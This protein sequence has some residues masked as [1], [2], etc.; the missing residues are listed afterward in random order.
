[1]KGNKNEV[2]SFT[3]IDRKSFI[4]GMVTAFAEC[5]ANECKK[6]ALSPPFYPE[7]YET[8]LQEVVSIAKDQGIF[9][10]YEENLDI[11]ANARLNWFVLYKYPEVLGEYQDLR[12]RGFNPAFNLKEFSN[13]LSYGTVWG[14]GAENVIP[15]VRE[16]RVTNDTCATVLLKPGDWPIQSAE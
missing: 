8:V 10:W 13:F 9:V 1:M 15:N 14:E 12:K 7:D 6:A 4:L 16:K 11:P 3:G 5:V 2:M